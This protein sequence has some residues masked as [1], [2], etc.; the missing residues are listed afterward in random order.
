[1][2]RIVLCDDDC[3]FMRELNQ[4]ITQW[5][6]LNCSESVSISEYSDAAYLARTIRAGES[7]DLFFVDVEMP[8][9]NGLKLAELIR[10]RLPYAI[11]IFLTSHSEFS[12]EG[13]KFGAL[14]YIPKLE[15]N[16]RL[17]ESLVAAQQEISKWEQK[18]LT[19]WHYSDAI[20]IPYCDIVYIRHVLRS[21]QI[22]TVNQG[23]VKDN[24]GL[25]AL[26]DILNDE[27]FI[28]IARSTFVNL[29]YI[30]QI[31][32]S[33][34]ILR[35]MERLPISRKMLTSVKGTINRLWGG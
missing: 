7:A 11:I 4:R 24:R 23:L 27:R 22:V 8:T 10:E 25:K 31:K 6:N 2:L 32:G 16:K 19:V 5:A 20:R 30:R 14:R 33:E 1:M 17:P 34:L 26:H 18:Y 35:N 15:L 9:I 28:Y 13:Y 21:S 29:D 12:L 3:S